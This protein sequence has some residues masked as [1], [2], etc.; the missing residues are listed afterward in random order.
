MGASTKRDSKTLASDGESL[1]QFGFPVAV[2]GDAAV[3]G[4]WG[5]DDASFEEGAAYVFAF[6]LR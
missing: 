6:A 1:D 3:I 4:A 2:N 5:D